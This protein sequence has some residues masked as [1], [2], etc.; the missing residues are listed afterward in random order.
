MTRRRA[1]GQRGFT[2]V[3]LIIA[4]AIVGSLLLVA[5]AGLRVAVGAWSRGDAHTEAQ[6]H[7]RSL[8][9]TLARSLGAAY[10]Y[11]GPR[12]QGETPAL[13][14]RGDAERIEFVTP[15]SPFPAPI[16]VAFTAVVIELGSIEGRAALVVRQ[17]ILPNHGPFNETPVVFE[18]PLVTSVV[19][20]YLGDNGWQTE[21]DAEAEGTLP[22]AVKLALAGPKTAPAGSRQPAPPGGGREIP[23]LTIALGGLRK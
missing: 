13:L 3:E 5:F 19:L 9:V 12:R 14:F 10:A 23:A 21:W 4:L 1:R 16:P 20:S 22:R 6:Q 2:L 7:T 8:S 11:R 17:R 15:A 18:D